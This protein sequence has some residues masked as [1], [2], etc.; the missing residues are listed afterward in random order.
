MASGVRPGGREFSDRLTHTHAWGPALEV[1]GP[2]HSLRP[3]ALIGAHPGGR[4]AT[5]HS[6]RAFA[7]TGAHP[8]G[9]GAG[10]PALRALAE[11]GAGG[12]AS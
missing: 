10:G 8:G 9:R 2:R 3:L 4:G 6:L 12:V 11:R 5:H 1:D 7:G